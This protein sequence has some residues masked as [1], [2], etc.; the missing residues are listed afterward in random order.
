MEHIE[1]ISWLPSSDE[2]ILDSLEHS[3]EDLCVVLPCE[4]SV[5]FY[6]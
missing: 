5:F 4:T 3:H 2:M 6:T 1:M